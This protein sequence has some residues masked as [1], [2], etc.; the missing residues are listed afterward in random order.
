MCLLWP[1]HSF[2]HLF[3]HVFPDAAGD[4]WCR[5]AQSPVRRFSRFHA[6]FYPNVDGGQIRRCLSRSAA[7]HLLA[8]MLAKVGSQ[9]FGV[10]VRPRQPRLFLLCGDL[11]RACFPR[12]S[13][14]NICHHPDCRWSLFTATCLSLRVLLFARDTV[15]DAASRRAIQ[16][17][18][19]RR[20]FSSR[21]HLHL[22]PHLSLF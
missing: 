18:K 9:R 21:F 10:L 15:V 4:Q 7:R 6:G 14:P 3:V 5:P 1:N 16:S 20:V 11:G 19:P 22:C 13:R 12:Q 17:N 2:D 8:A